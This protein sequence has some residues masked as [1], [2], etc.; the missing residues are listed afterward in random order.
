MFT[1]YMRK[2]SLI[3]SRVMLPLPNLSYSYKKKTPLISFLLKK[4]LSV[5]KLFKSR[6]DSRWPRVKMILV[7]DTTKYILQHVSCQFKFLPKKK[8]SLT[9]PC[10]PPLKGPIQ[11]CAAVKQHFSHPIYFHKTV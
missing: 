10:N 5:K 9:R 1:L 6:E 2:I 3:W 8:T 11:S 7:K 4:F